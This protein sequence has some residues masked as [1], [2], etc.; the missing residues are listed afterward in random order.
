[1]PICC[2]I[3]CDDWAEAQCRAILDN[4]RK[5]MKP[6]SRLLIVEMVLPEGDAPHPGKMIDLLMLVTTGGQERSESEYR[7]LL[8]SSGFQLTRVVP[9]RSAVSI[10]EATVA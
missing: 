1:M 10:V 5:A 4:V 9:T 3:S 8:D 2:R 6:T 7:Q